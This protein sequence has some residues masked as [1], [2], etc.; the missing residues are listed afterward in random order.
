MVTN[1]EKAKSELER[2]GYLN[3]DMN[4]S[5]DLAAEILKLKKEKIARVWWY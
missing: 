2:V 3:L 5:I 4:P 1:L